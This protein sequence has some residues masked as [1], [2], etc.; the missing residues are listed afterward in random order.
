[1]KVLVVGANGQIG[2]QLTHLLQDHEGYTVR[3]MVRK[4]ASAPYQAAGI[5]CVLANLEGSVKEL[6]DAAKNCQAV[7]F[8]AGSGRATGYDK[9]LLIDLDGAV[10]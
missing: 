7:V 5:E 3:A 10:K 9:T 2:K 8:A 6:A 4:G 1:M